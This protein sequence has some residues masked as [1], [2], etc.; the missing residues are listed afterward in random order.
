MNNILARF[1]EDSGGKILLLEV[2]SHAKS[3]TQ[4]PSAGGEHGIGRDAES[5]APSQN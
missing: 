2:F 4:S 3:H 5:V 1:G